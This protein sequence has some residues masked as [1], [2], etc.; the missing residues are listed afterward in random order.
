M[1]LPT[2][3]ELAQSIAA[4][5]APPELEQ[6]IAAAR[7]GD[8]ATARRLLSLVTAQYDDSGLAWLWLA[9]V[10]ETDGERAFCLDLA[11]KLGPNTALAEQALQRLPAGTRQISPEGRAYLVTPPSRRPLSPEQPLPTRGP[12]QSVTSVSC[13]FAAGWALVGVLLVLLLPRNEPL[14]HRTISSYAGLGLALTGSLALVFNLDWRRW[15]PVSI[16]TVVAHHKARYRIGEGGNARWAPTLAAHPI[17]RFTTEDG[18]TLEFQMRDRGEPSRYPLGS[19]FKLQYD[20]ADPTLVRIPCPDSEVCGSAAVHPARRAL[21][22]CSLGI[23]DARHCA[24]GPPTC[25]ACYHGAAADVARKR[26]QDRYVF[27]DTH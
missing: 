1:Y 22:S 5:G 3:S 17:I 8:T 20:P 24:H 9:A 26:I 11:R 19:P 7:E 15:S 27:F 2:R 10:V 16:G 14:F 18:T 13:L 25:A 6:G 21:L 4:R 23:A 12:G